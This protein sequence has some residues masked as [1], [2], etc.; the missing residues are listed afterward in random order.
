MLSVFSFALPPLGGEGRGEGED[1]RGLDLGVSLHSAR[2]KATCN[3]QQQNGPG[4]G[5]LL[6]YGPGPK[7]E[8]KA[9]LHGQKKESKGRGHGTP[10]SRPAGATPERVVRAPRPR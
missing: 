1:P 9:A 4:K 5:L 2:S 6:N 3:M 7:V 10:S 8:P